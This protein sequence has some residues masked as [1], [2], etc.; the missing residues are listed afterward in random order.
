MSPVISMSW[1][2]PSFQRIYEAVLSS[3]GRGIFE[4]YLRVIKSKFCPKWKNMKKS[5]IYDDAVALFGVL[6]G[7]DL[8]LAVATVIS[9]IAVKR[10]LDKICQ[11]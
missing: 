11:S 3:L 9:A 7:Q 2:C 1:S 8:P 6:L 10:G 5:G 4:Q